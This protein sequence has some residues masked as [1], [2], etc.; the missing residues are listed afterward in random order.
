MHDTPRCEICGAAQGGADLLEAEVIGEVR[1]VCADCH[2]Y[3]QDA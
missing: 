2:G 3:V 1:T